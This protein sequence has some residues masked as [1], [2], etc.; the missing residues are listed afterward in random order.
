MQPVGVVEKIVERI[1]VTKMIPMVVLKIAVERVNCVVLKKLG[2]VFLLVG[3]RG[4]LLQLWD[5]FAGQQS[6]DAEEKES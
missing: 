6:A 4:R 5:G 1:A 3:G 2:G